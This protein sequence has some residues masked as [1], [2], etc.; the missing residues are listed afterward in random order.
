MNSKI[1]SEIWIYPIKSLAGI[2]LQKSLVMA[3]GL[4]YDR[5]WMLVDE[6]GRFLTQRE[7][8]AMAMFQVVLENNQFLI[9]KKACINNN[10]SIGIR[11]D[12]NGEASGKSLKV[13][14]W[15]NEVEAL[16]VNPAF[17]AWFS[18]QLNLNCKLVFFPEKNQR[19]IDPEFAK[20]KSKSV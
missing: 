9:S 20:K 18:E 15:K 11:L 10:H 2:S 1:L 3:K 6:N 5:R 7:H 17:S 13:Q 16:E 14:I 12:L 19:E 4:Q 8:P